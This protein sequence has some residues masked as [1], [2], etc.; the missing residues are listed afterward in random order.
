MK[1]DEQ[2]GLLNPLRDKND[3]TYLGER[4]T[5]PD[6]YP[7]LV[8]KLDSKSGIEAFHDRSAADFFSSHEAPETVGISKKFDNATRSTLLCATVVLKQLYYCS[9]VCKRLTHN[10]QPLPWDDTLKMK[11]L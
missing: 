2:S 6:L 4:W 1:M 3:G 10:V 5:T 9:K 11:W 7:R 8:Q